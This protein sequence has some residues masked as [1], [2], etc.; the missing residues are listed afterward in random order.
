M[1]ATDL[2]PKNMAFMTKKMLHSIGFFCIFAC[3]QVAAQ[4]QAPL[5][6]TLETNQAGPNAS[7]DVL[8]DKF[9]AT[10]LPVQDTKLVIFRH[11]KNAQSPGVVTLF[12]NDR[13]HASL[14]AGGYTEVCLPRGAV[15][16]RLRT[17]RAA[18]RTNPSSTQAQIDIAE[19][20]SYLSVFDSAGVPAMLKVSEAAALND[21]NDLLRQVHTLSRVPDQQSCTGATA[22]PGSATPQPSR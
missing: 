12:I 17:T 11:P 1:Q 7:I 4:T 16:I 5:P 10:T 19:Q 8:R 3:A 21:L 20:I 6:L 2:W 22:T 15:N 14:V 18:E 9:T 13:Y